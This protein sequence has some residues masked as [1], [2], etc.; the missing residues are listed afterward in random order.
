MIVTAIIALLYLI[1]PLSRPREEV[2]LFTVLNSGSILPEL[3]MPTE[4]G[5]GR[6]SIEWESK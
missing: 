3:E 6:S 5:S 1:S 4:T 2:G